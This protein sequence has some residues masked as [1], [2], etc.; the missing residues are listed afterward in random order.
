MLNNIFQK[1]FLAITVF[2]FFVLCITSC[3]HQNKTDEKKH[4]DVSEVPLKLNFD[5]FDN[6]LM[7]PDSLNEKNVPALKRKYGSF[8]TIFCRK[9]CPIPVHMTSDTAIARQLNFFKFDKDIK[10]IYSSIDTMYK[11]DHLLQQQLTEVFKHYHHYYPDSIIPHVVTF[12][13]A[14]NYATI[15]TDSILGIGLDFYLGSDCPFYTGT[16]FPTYLTKRLRGEYIVP[17]CV[18][19]WYQKSNDINK[20]KND[21]LSQMV[22]YGKMMYYTDLMMPDAPDSIKLGYSDM[23][24]KW[25]AGNEANMWAALIEQNLL[26]STNMRQYMKFISDGPTTQGFPKESPS[27]IGYY[28]GWQIVKAYMEKHPEITLAQLCKEEDAQKILNES[29]YKPNK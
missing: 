13:S 4:I 9:I 15:T 24:V 14:F 12:F 5:R 18:Q 7:S 29:K 8:F 3:T 28:V 16:N 1:Q 23:Q 10:E 19:G 22:Y 2:L 6:D 26:Y 27:R 17:N 21:L 25:C 11:D 20:V